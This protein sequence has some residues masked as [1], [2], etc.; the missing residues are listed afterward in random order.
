[1]LFQAVS[2]G[3]HKTQ[4]HEGKSK[5]TGPRAQNRSTSPAPDSARSCSHDTKLPEIH[6]H[7]RRLTSTFHHAR[8]SLVQGPRPLMH[9]GAQSLSHVQLF[10]IPWTVAF[11]APVFMGFSRQEYWS[12]L[13]FLLQVIFLTRYRIHMSCISCI[14]RWILYHHTTWGALPLLTLTLNSLI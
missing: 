9:I 10:E 12:G 1:M 6:S 3:K 8:T 14:G 5:G 4:R 13:P 7:I 2:D 11:Q